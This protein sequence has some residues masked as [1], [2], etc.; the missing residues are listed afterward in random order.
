MDFDVWPRPYVRYRANG[1]R[2]V[3]TGKCHSLFVVSLR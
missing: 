1:A 2:L 3:Y